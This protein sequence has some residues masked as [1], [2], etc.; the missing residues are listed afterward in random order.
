MPVAVAAALVDCVMKAG[1]SSSGM[2]QLAAS[3]FRDCT[4][5]ASG[6]PKLG[7][8]MFVTNKKAVLASLSSFKRSL[9]EIEKLIKQGD[10][11]AIQERLSKIN[12]FRDSMYR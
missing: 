5:I 6:D 11:A 1:R 9:S 4:R 3:G 8:D 10:H 7:T 2:K 12:N